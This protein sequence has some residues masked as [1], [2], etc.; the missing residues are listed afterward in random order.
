[1]NNWKVRVAGVLLML[2]TAWYLPWALANLNWAAPWLSLP[3]AAASLM[4][5]VMTIVTAI[6]HWQYS[7]PEERLVP[8][9]QE[10]EVAVILPTYGEPPKMVYETAKSVLE[11]DYP[12][13]KI[14]LVIGDDA[15]RKAIRSVVERLRQEHPDAFVGYHEPPRRGDPRRRGEAKA[16]NLNSVLDALDKY[17]PQASFLET[18]DADDKVGDPGFLRQATGQ[19]LADPKVAFVQT[20]KEAV[21]S[22]G[23]PFGNLE[24]LFYRKAMLAKNAANAAFP[25]GSGLVW[26]REALDEIG[27]FPTWNLVE[28][29]QSGVE[30]LR[31][32]WRGVYL[33][34]VGAVGQ[35]APED[36]PNS[37]KQRGTWATDAMRITFWGSKRGLS[38]RQN[39]QFSELGFFYTLSFAVLV[40]AITPVFAL[41][42]GLYPLVTTPGAYALHFWPYAAAVELLLVSLADGLPFE[43]VWRARQTWLGMAPVYARATLTALIYG[44]NR[45][46]TY[47]VTRKK[48]VYGWYWR[49]VLPQ[50]LLFLA[51]VAASLYHLVTHSLLYTADLGSLFWAGIFVL[52]LS[53]V[54]RNS[55]H[56]LEVE[57]I[58]ARAGRR[59]RRSTLE[60]ILLSV[61]LLKRPVG[62]YL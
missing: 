36:I 16:G 59:L 50:I 14:R 15:H 17:A 4:T 56:G 58:I 39:M 62:R 28:D 29:L 27:G 10:P 49:E 41:M 6:N 61:R 31:R 32:G 3:F 52:G 34:I 43:A 44:P 42:F 21:V 55:W 7:V 5:A 19:L 37:V 1:M 26:R 22:P 20:V 54:V 40:F 2:A 53:R 30:A 48:H 33:P 57:E 51:L 47:R 45:K 11:Q 35:T 38:L 23:D 9:G 25:C 12:E 18:R 24:P 13:G 60:K 8:V 46:P